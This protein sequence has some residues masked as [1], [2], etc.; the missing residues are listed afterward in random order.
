MIKNNTSSVATLILTCD[1]YSDL[2]DGFFHQ[3]NKNYTLQ[4]KIYFAS[5]KLTPK[6][7][8]SNIELILT[9]DERCWGENLIKVLN[10]IKEEYVLI[11]IE[12][13]YLNQKTNNEVF[14]EIN[15][16]INS[17]NKN[18]NHIK[19]LPYFKKNNNGREIIYEIDK[20]APYRVHLGGI[21]R[22]KYLK[23]LIELDES[24]WDFEKNGTARAKL[25]EGFYCVYPPL[26][27]TVNMVEKGM[28]MSGSLKWAK[29]N[30][31]PINIETRKQ[32]PILIEIKSRFK[33]IIFNL[34]IKIDY[35]KRIK[36]LNLIKKCLII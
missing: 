11:N 27:T 25:D 20:D 5:N 36:L 34:I 12:D 23:Q 9:G 4:N 2:W 1:K 13:L 32:K 16:F 19:T 31:V 21:W 22:I 30:H 24:P 18:I 14:D 15:K 29:D 3:F 6:S 17:G 8:N 7:C 28:W 35:K 10:Q 26:Y 33:N